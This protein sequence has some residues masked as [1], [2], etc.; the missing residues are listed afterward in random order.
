MNGSERNLCNSATEEVTILKQVT[1]EMNSN[2]TDRLLTDCWGEI[3][4]EASLGERL[5]KNGKWTRTYYIH[6]FMLREKERRRRGETKN[7]Q[8]EEDK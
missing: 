1:A 7:R 8:S 2:V 3:D 5:F 4:R 6:R